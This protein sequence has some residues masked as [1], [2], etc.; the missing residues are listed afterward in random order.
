MKL[1]E[2]IMVVDEAGGTREIRIWQEVKDAGHMGDPHATVDGMKRVELDDGSYVREL[3]D[4][5]WEDLLGRR[6]ARV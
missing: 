1:I 5:V 4:G 2:R 6:Y 3:Q